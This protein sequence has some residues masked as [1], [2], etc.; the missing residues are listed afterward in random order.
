M[1][2]AHSVT[3]HGVE[4]GVNVAIREDHSDGI[5]G[6]QD[7]DSMCARDDALT[8]AGAPP[9]VTRDGWKVHEQQTEWSEPD[10][11][12]HLAVLSEELTM[13]IFS[14]LEPT[15]LISLSCVSRTM[16]RLAGDEHLW[17]ALYLRHLCLLRAV[18]WDTLHPRGGAS[19]KALFREQHFCGARRPGLPDS[20][21]PQ[22]A[23]PRK[24]RSLRKARYSVLYIGRRGAGKATIFY[25]LKFGPSHNRT[26]YLGRLGETLV[27]EVP[28]INTVFRFEVWDLPDGGPETEIRPFQPVDAIIVVDDGRGPPP[29]CP[30][31]PVLVERLSHAAQVVSASAPPLL[32]LANKMDLRAH[33]GPAASGAAEFARRLSLIDGRGVGA[34]WLSRS[35]STSSTGSLSSIGSGSFAVHPG[36]SQSAHGVH[37]SGWSL[38]SASLPPPYVGASLPQGLG[39]WRVQCCCGLSL[40]GVL[41]GLAW[42]ST[43]LGSTD[44]RRSRALSSQ[45]LQSPGSQRE[46]RH[47]IS[48]TGSISPTAG[49]WGAPH[50]TQTGRMHAPL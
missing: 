21:A 6:M 38:P 17:K 9:G 46:S 2:A 42:L 19:W 24:P 8:I 14:Y 7:M 39:R 12:C 45:A 3:H 20:A 50:D 29:G 47:S 16:H 33:L 36:S 4:P 43:E 22:D 32:V 18:G 35:S 31:L 25:H 40:E 34:G 10:R 26:Y 44:G 28:D 30:S 48:S 27:L 41:D 49:M 15:D 5:D 11:P 13:A 23:I 1:D 37:A